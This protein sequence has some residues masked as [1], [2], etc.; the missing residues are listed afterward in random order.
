M[1][2]NFSLAHERWIPVL[3]MDATTDTLGLEQLFR[4][5]AD[6]AAVSTGDVLEDAAVNKLLLACALAAGNGS[7][8]N[9]ESIAQW[10][11]NNAAKFDVLDREKPFGQNPR[12]RAI[13]E[14]MWT[15]PR[16]QFY[17]WTSTDGLFNS[18]SA[19]VQP[20]VTTE[21]LD[22]CVRQILVRHS[23]SAGTLTKP[24]NRYIGGSSRTMRK[25]PYYNLPFVWFE[26]TTLADSVIDNATRLNW[27]NS[28]TFHF[29]WP[30][31]VDAMSDIEKPGLL[32]ALT[33]PFKSVLLAVNAQHDVTTMT[34]FDGLRL[35]TM[36]DVSLLPHTTWL[37]DEKTYAP[38]SV[39]T[40]IN[41][42]DST[43]L[44]WLHMLM[45]YASGPVGTSLVYN[46][47]PSTARSVV[48]TCLSGDGMKARIDDNVCWRLPAPVIDVDTAH[49]LYTMYLDF[50]RFSYGIFASASEDGE[51][52]AV[53]EKYADE[54]DRKFGEL[55]LAVFDGTVSIERAKSL[56]PELY[57]AVKRDISKDSDVRTAVKIINKEVPQWTTL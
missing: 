16:T 29:T 25:S 9:V 10:C 2:A 34:V 42:N 15:A 17:D 12:M 18:F 54:R 28:G 22:K 11:A 43:R 14:D 8:T 57:D 31:N 49:Q 55:A 39:R 26:S 20:E 1:T 23:F 36:D 7:L 13:P 44:S 27:S 50:R 45:C 52:N 32:D 41:N 38:K 33:A 4:E 51:A 56:V 3:R 53:Y 21:Q 30:K 19:M 5:S 46:D 6:I 37:R 40:K 47:A 48:M 35:P 24:L